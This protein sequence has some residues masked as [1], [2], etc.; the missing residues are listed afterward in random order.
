MQT[1]NNSLIR[2]IKHDLRNSIS[3]SEDL[4]SDIK[5]RLNLTSTDQ[6]STAGFILSLFLDPLV[7]FLMS[8]LGFI[9]SLMDNLINFLP[10]IN[11]RQSSFLKRLKKEPVSFLLLSILIMAI[12]LGYL[13][14]SLS[15]GSVFYVLIL[16]LLEVI[17]ACLFFYYYLIYRKYSY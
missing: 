11:T 1:L 10:V 15:R 5:N 17:F 9:G 3:H 6:I 2:G 8:I 12:G 7:L 14:P 4:V 16:T 13:N